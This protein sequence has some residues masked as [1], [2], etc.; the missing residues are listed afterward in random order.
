MVYTQLMIIIGL[1]LDDGKSFTS[2]FFKTKIMHFLGR[3]S[4]ALYLIHEPL[5]YYIRV[6]FHGIWN[7]AEHENKGPDPSPNWTIIIHIIISLIFGT[8]LTIYL[9]EPARKI[10]KNWW[11]KRKQQKEETNEV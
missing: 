8:L 3:I 10:L 9:E 7:W 2:K 6:C 4:M 5:I 11:E 1:C